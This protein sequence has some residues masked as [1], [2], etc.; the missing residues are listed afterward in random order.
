MV[1][2]EPNS[3]Q[4]SKPTTRCNIC[5]GL[6]TSGKPLCSDH[7]LKMPY[8]EYVQE[9]ISLREKEIAQINDGGAP[10][11]HGHV[12]GEAVRLLFWKKVTVNGFCH[13]FPGLSHRGAQSLVNFLVELGYAQ[14]TKNTKGTRVI[15]GYATMIES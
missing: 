4:D 2:V 14:E 11:E 3:T 9:Q 12:V 10:I 8:S 5:G 6:T 1:L 13:E 15:Q 7:I